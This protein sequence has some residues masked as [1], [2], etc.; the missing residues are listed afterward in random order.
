MNW[1][2]AACSF[3]WLTLFSV[4]A[5]RGAVSGHAWK[6]MSWHSESVTQLTNELSI[7]PTQT[8][9]G[10]DPLFSLDESCLGR[11]DLLNVT[12]AVPWMSDLLKAAPSSDNKTGFS[13]LNSS[14]K[15]VY[16]EKWPGSLCQYS[17]S[18]AVAFE[19]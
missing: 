6:T 19:G 16:R 1:T 18:S 3:A 8:T 13:P 7:R 11:A 17:L 9:A 14:L 10:P 12:T 15:A 5:S 4:F 2:R